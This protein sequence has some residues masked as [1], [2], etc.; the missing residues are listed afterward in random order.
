MH[1]WHIPAL[2]IATVLMAGPAWAQSQNASMDAMPGMAPAP[3]P[4][5]RAMMAGM[6]KMSHDMS[7]VPMTGNADQDFVAMML[8]HH[9]GAVAM[10][11]VEVKYGRDPAMRQMAKD[12]IAAQTQEI[13]EMRRWQAQHPHG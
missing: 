12:I 4:A 9:Q 11:E 1:S 6:A 5:D 7:H 2:A 8:P 3:S 13:A 10:A